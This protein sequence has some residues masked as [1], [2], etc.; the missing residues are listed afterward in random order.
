[1]VE[2]LPTFEPA[3]FV[4]FSSFKK[5]TLLDKFLVPPLLT[6]ADFS[7]SIVLHIRGPFPIFSDSSFVL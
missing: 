7:R 5:K 2:E 4:K 1:M 6:S 3:D